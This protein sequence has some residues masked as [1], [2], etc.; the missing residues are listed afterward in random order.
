MSW[1]FSRALVA[2]SSAGTCSDGEP[3]ARSSTTP[4]PQAYLC[5]DKTTDAWRRFPS[6]MTCEP[7]TADRGEELLT[8]YLAVFPARTFPQ[9][10][11]ERESTAND[12]DCGPKW[13]ASLAR[14]DRD[15]RSWKT[16]QCLLAGDLE[17]FSETFPNWGMTVDGEL[18]RRPTPSSLLAIRA[19][20]TC[21]NASGLSLQIGTPMAN[22]KKRS[23]DFQR[24]TPSLEEFVKKLPT[25][26]A[27][28]GSKGTRSIS[29]AMKELQRGVN[30][31]L[32]TFVA[33]QL[34]TPKAGEAT[35]QLNS[36]PLSEHIGGKLNPQWV[37]WLMGWPIG[38]T[39]LAALATDKWQQWR[40]SHGDH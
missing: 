10:E 17:E 5:R 9:P 37:E 26:R 18:F 22:N 3:S 30:I 34:P 28:D 35:M 40:R 11:E 24:K 12:P 15:S 13:H 2:A 36:R 19:R 4:T 33:T 1:L 8:S 25:P 14:Y 31:D 6:G 23:V 27:T 21:G 20:I 29:G 7:L 39:D 16:R 38:W 32:P